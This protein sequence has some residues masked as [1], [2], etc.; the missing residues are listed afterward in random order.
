MKSVGDFRFLVLRLADSSFCT[1]TCTSST[2]TTHSNFLCDAVPLPVCSPP[3]TCAS[4][5]AAQ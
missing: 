2:T 1:N 4:P 5:T 3:P